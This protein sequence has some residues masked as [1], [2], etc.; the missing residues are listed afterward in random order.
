MFRDSL[1][2]E[3]KTGLMKWKYRNEHV[4]FGHLCELGYRSTFEG[5]NVIDSKT[6]FDGHLGFASYIGSNSMI[7]A[8]VGKYTCIG[9]NVRVVQ[10]IHPSHTRVSV[11]P[12][13]YSSRRQC[14]TSYVTEDTF[15][16]L[17]FAD[18]DGRYPVIIGNDVWIGYGATILAGCKIGDGAIVAAN[19]TV[20]A[21][22]APYA[23]VG[24]TPAKMIRNRFMPNEIEFLQRS[25]WWDR[26]ETWLKEHAK[27]FDN[28]RTFME[29]PQ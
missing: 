20:V 14:G 15:E 23:V 19:S 22:V 17:R 11:H 3:L 4:I 2:K 7:L 25:R 9:P 26:P 8:H 6:V 29:I 27:D 24:G 16:E 1:K 13:F 18:K 21:D 5:Y 10:G 28:I 12:A